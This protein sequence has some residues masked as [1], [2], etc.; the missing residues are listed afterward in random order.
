MANPAPTIPDA[1]TDVETRKKP[2]T[3][4]AKCLNPEGDGK[5]HHNVAELLST[6]D[7][8]RI[9]QRVT[10]EYDIDKTSRAEW[11]DLNREG[12][13][14]AKQALE[15]KNTPW[16]RASSVKYPLITTAAIQ[17]A[18][19]AYPEIVQGSEIVKCRVQGEDPDNMKQEIATRISQHMSWQLLEEMDGWEEETDKL[20]HVLPVAGMC[21]RKTYFDNIEKVNRSDLCLADDVVIHYKAKNM[22]TVRRITHVL[23]YYQNDIYERIARGIWLDREL[24][25]AEDAE[26]PGEEDAPHKFLEQ[27]RW[28]DLDGDGYEEPYIVTCHK[29]LAR[30]VRIVPRFEVTGIEFSDTGKLVRIKPTEYFTKFGFIPAPDGSIYDIGFGILLYP[31]NESIN[32]IMNQLIDAGTLHNLQ[33]GWIDKGLREK[34]GVKAFSPG[35]WRKTEVKLVG[36]KR[37]QDMVLPLPTKEPSAVLFQM[38][39][40]L[41]DA[42]EKIGTVK[43]ILTGKPP[44]SNV[45]ATTILALIEQGLKVFSAIYKRIFRSMGEEYRK[46]F[47]LNAVYMDE[48]KYFRLMDT[49]Q[50]VG[51]QDYNVQDLDVVPVADP[52][53]SSD[54]QRIAKSQAIAQTISG[55]PNV[56]EDEITERMIQAINVPDPERLVIPPEQRQPPPPPPEIMLKGRELFLKEQEHELNVIKTIAQIDE[57]AAKIEKLHADAIKSIAQAEAE[58]VGPQLQSYVAQVQQLGNVAKERIRMMGQMQIAKEAQKNAQTSQQG[59][60][61]S[62]AAAGRNP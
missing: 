14:L 21:F 57:I 52:T 51:L 12:M 55:R 33:S 59:G 31:I 16:P 34:G 11:E 15:Q 54:V 46:L 20:L 49:Q 62:V 29:D 28:L 24:P 43:D 6:Q 47:A 53:M 50:T 41:I 1:R 18:A 30:V 35:E 22:H 44:G 42:G 45:P 32:V 9:G 60:G 37:L 36:G 56:N 17:F 48:E 10:R 8:D 5:P 23:E 27:H 3:W 4:I 13:K 2:T 7:L 26:H 58:E 40:L 25:R 61:G 39:G 19:R 38:L